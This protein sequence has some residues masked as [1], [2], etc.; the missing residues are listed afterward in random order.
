MKSIVAECTMQH[1][2]KGKDFNANSNNYMT[3]NHCIHKVLPIDSV[4]ERRLHLNNAKL[5]NT[6]LPVLSDVVTRLWIFLTTFSNDSEPSDHYAVYVENILSSLPFQTIKHLIQ[7]SVPHYGRPMKRDAG[8]S[9][10]PHHISTTATLEQRNLC[11]R[12]CANRY[13]QTVM[14][15]FYSFI[16]LY[17]F[18]PPKVECDD[19]SMFGCDPSIL[20]HRGRGGQTLLLRAVEHTFVTN[21]NEARKNLGMEESG[22]STSISTKEG[23][24]GLGHGERVNTN[25]TISTRLVCIKFMADQWNF[26]TEIQ[27][28]SQLG[29]LN[30]THCEEQ[31]DGPIVP[32][33]AH[34]NAANP[35]QLSDL[36][37]ASDIKDEHFH[38]ITLRAGSSSTS[39]QNH[40]NDCV[41][42]SK[43]PY[44][45]VLP[46]S[47]DR[48]LYDSYL[49][50]C[51]GN[52]DILRDVCFQMGTALTFLRGKGLSYASFNMR[53]FIA[54]PTNST[55][56]TKLRVWKMI[57]LSSEKLIS[58][59]HS[60]GYLAGVVRN[61]NVLF[62]T[63]KF[64]PEMFTKLDALELE[65][66]YTYWE[67]VNTIVDFDV[68]NMYLVK[69][70]ISSE[71]GD[72]YVIKCYFVHNKGEGLDNISLP[73]LPYK[74]VPASESVDVWSFGTL[75]FTLLSGGIPL[76]HSN[77]RT[78][79]VINYKA[80]AS[81][82]IDTAERLV[83]QH[84]Q[85][86]VSQDL[87]LHIL[88]SSKECDGMD[89]H[90]LLN[91]T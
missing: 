17:D 22:T 57:D 35:T 1:N 15:S 28:C 63:T 68:M 52:N 69:P 39:T 90:T 14:H 41:E 66:Y 42:L 59:N 67:K 34:Y 36:K 47:T 6:N 7:I 77:V 45:I 72:T 20:I 37:F 78:G 19:H 83:E 31:D 49:H 32:I 30:S 71:T 46:L 18:T 87:L 73:S 84:I 55:S 64:P 82:D 58:D 74:L 13:C 48:N 11:V 61:R 10:V 53:N 80:I 89:M 38:H 81:W 51:I 75:L 25:L 29:L 79:H 33:L 76:F 44:T 70:W 56:N 88:V 9:Y 24:D 26:E 8:G 5:S 21:K 62:D 91:D 60:S 2:E 23:D 40:K 3:K 27:M 16:G 85:D 43:Y 86:P 4:E 65:M 54:F 12:E 50:D